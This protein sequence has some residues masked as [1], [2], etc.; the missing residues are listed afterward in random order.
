MI[1]VAFGLLAIVL[2]W[3]KPQH[4]AEAVDDEVVDASVRPLVDVDAVVELVQPTRISAA[5]AEL[6][7]AEQA[8][9]ARLVA[10]LDADDVAAE[11]EAW[12]AEELH[13]LGVSL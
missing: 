10:E 11:A 13:R 1:S 9:Y 12:L 3:P 8:S 6:I 2:L 7:A 4:P 5:V